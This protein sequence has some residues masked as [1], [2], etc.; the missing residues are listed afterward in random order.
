[1]VMDVKGRS[2][3]Y[4]VFGMMQWNVENQFIKIK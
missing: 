4:D 1:M 2:K 3:L